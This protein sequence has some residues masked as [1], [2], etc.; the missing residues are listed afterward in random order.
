[1]KIVFIIV[2]YG[3]KDVTSS[4]IRSI[5]KHQEF[6]VSICVVDNSNNF[7][8][9]VSSEFIEILKPSKKFGFFGGARFAYDNLTSRGLFYDFYAI[10]NNDLILEDN[11]VFQKLKTL[12]D[13]NYDIIAPDIITLDGVHQNP[14]RKF[15]PSR[16]IRCYYKLI[17]SNIYVAKVFYF[18]N[19]IRKKT[20]QK[21][22]AL[23]TEEVIFSAHGAVM[24]V[25]KSFFD[26]GGFIDNG[27]FLYGEEDSIAFQCDMLNCKILYTPNIRIK[28]LE[29]VN[30]RDVNFSKKY[31]FQKESFMYIKQNY[32][33]SKFF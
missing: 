26:K 8:L 28:H 33:N 29:S 32:P 24:F 7:S 12:I 15:R 30:T 17:Y 18:L 4:F 23:D 14:H 2:H 25:K 19:R 6:D 21:D 5:Q 16:N 11:S 31:S 3:N 22:I 10:C 1:M 9:D 13:E 27:F 20:N